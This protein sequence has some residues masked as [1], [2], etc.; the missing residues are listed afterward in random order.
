MTGKFRVAASIAAL[1]GALA[2][3]ACEHAHFIAGVNVG[4]PAPLAFGPVGSAPSPG[5]VWTDGY[6]IWG[7]NRWVWRPGRWV[8]PP[9]P[10]YVWRNPT[11]EHYRNGYRMYPGRWVRR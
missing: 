8:R 3:S 4:P 1:V 2:L 7:G 10:G 11:Y 9:H 6:Y 5:W